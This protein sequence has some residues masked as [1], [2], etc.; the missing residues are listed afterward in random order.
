MNQI[1]K[2][3]LT[4]D[5]KVLKVL[6]TGTLTKFTTNKGIFVKTYEERFFKLLPG[7]DIEEIKIKKSDPAATES[8]H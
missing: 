8:E 7:N 6:N 3:F 1:E 4:N 2:I 5:I